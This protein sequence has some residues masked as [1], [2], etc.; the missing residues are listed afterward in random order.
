VRL[1]DETSRRKVKWITDVFQTQQNRHWFTE[2][3]F[4]ALMRLRGIES[5]GASG[6]AEAFYSRKSV[7]DVTPGV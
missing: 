1:D 5:G 6:Y 2:E 3:T 4:F 7:I